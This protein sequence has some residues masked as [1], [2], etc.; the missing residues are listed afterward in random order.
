ML[1]QPAS[2][3]APDIHA[4]QMLKTYLGQVL[5]TYLAVERSFALPALVVGPLVCVRLTPPCNEAP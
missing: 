3:Q 1:T 2:C 5:K 4:Q